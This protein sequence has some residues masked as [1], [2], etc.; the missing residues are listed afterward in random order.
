MND[1]TT[2]DSQKS[3]QQGDHQNSQGAEPALSH[4]Q[5]LAQFNDYF[6]IEQDLNVNVIPLEDERVLPS[7]DSFIRN[8]PYSFRLASEV[9]TLEASALRPLRNLSHVGEDLVDFLKA[10]SRKIDLI[11]SYI[12]TMEDDDDN[13]L[14]AHS[15][16]GGG[17][18]VLS[19]TEF[20]VGQLTQMK[21][22]LS[23]EA[24]AIFCYGEVLK[25]ERQGDKFLTQLYYARIR[26]DDREIIVRASLHQQ[27]KQLKI[28]A[29]SKRDSK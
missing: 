23:D 10:Q 15:F 8:M 5:K 9:S 7:Y 16:G 21:I 27:S 11:M 18:T 28:K 13:R 29:E 12:L 4:A 1:S 19:N 3:P 24:A 6:T 25:V 17:M 22:F 26:E 2:P 20:A 14:L